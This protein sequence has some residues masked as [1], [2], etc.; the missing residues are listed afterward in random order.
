MED[1]KYVRDLPVWDGAD[2]LDPDT[3]LPLKTWDAAMA[4]LDHDPQARPAHVVRFGRQV[5]A[6]GLIAGTPDTDRTVRYLTKYLTKA[7][8][9]T[10]ANDDEVEHRYDV[11]MDRL[12]NEVRFLPCSPDCGN[13][14]RFGIQPRTVGPGLEP[15]WCPSKAHSRAHLGLGGRRVLVSRGWSGKT[16]AG[17]RADRAQVIR[18]A[19][20]AAG[21][22]MAAADRMAAQVVDEFGERRFEWAAVVPGTGT[23]AHLLMGTILERRRWREQYERAKAK[24]AANV[25]PVDNSFG[26][27]NRIGGDE[28]GEALHTG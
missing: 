21:M 4:E 9:E 1:P 12:W 20:Q 7:L 25:P 8:A 11:H 23:K 14:L 10:Y 18:Q 15:G 16:L 13:W 28:D 17:H 6:K 2:Y 22:E 3:G 19:L 26:N 24:L 27:W 5:D